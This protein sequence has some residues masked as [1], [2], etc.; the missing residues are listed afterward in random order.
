[1]G[2]LKEIDVDRVDG[3]D[4]PAT[5][6]AFVLKKSAVIKHDE[7]TTSDEAEFQENVRAL[8]NSS[9]AVLKAISEA[10][11]DLPLTEDMANY[12]NEMAKSLGVEFDFKAVGPA[13][14]KRPPTTN[15][16]AVEHPEED[17]NPD[18][19]GEQDAEDPNDPNDPNNPKNKMPPP[20]KPSLKNIEGER[21]EV[22]AVDSAALGSAIAAALAPSLTSIAKS[23]DAILKQLQT[24]NEAEPIS[25][26]ISRSKQ[27][28]RSTRASESSVE[29]GSGMFTD[30][31]F[32]SNE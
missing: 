6:R 18:D 2:K 15:D 20:K 14:R 23:Q 10:G 9:S 32:G 27:P 25:K 8:A 17:P 4:V 19:M 31:V 21:T 28:K 3:V 24:L 11:D 5:R 13:A 7:A 1:M 22:S 29:L 16:D 26:S 30:L 12:L